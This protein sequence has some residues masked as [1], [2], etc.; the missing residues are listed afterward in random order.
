[1]LFLQ[2]HRGQRWCISKHCD[3]RFCYP[4]SQ[5]HYVTV[6]VY[7]GTTSRSIGVRHHLEWWNV[8]SVWN[9]LYL[10]F[11]LFSSSALSACYII[12]KFRTSMAKPTSEATIE[13]AASNNRQ[14]PHR[15]IIIILKPTLV[16]LWIYRHIFTVKMHVYVSVQCHTG[17]QRIDLNYLNNVW[18][19]RSQY[20]CR[21]TRYKSITIYKYLL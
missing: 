3:G 13:S 14:S 4:H 6:Y 10:Y 18:M 21:C 16:S 1:M 20:C 9:R 12:F 7:V 17:H 2:S 5:R 15:L 19:I 11:T 8:Y